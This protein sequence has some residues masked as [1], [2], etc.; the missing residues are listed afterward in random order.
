MWEAVSP[1]TFTE[2][3]SAP[4]VHIDIRFERYEHGDGDRFDGPGGTLAHAFFPQYGGD[5]HVDDTEYWTIDSFKG[6][7][8]LQTV[9]HELGKS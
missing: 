4:S 7:N 5:I 2:S 1:L 6:T 9:V 8:L 3:P